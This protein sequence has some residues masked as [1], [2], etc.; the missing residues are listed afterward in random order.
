MAFHQKA[1]A[2]TGAGP[3]RFGTKLRERPHSPVVA[4]RAVD[5][6]VFVALAISTVI[7]I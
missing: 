6:Q 5:L 2:S 7:S 1:A 4:H 3:A